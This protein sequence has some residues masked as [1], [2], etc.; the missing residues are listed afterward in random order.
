[1]R[2]PIAALLTD[3]RDID[4]QPSIK[5]KRSLSE[6]AYPT[7]SSFSNEPDLGGG[8]LL[9]GVSRV[10][11]RYE[12]IGVADPDRVSNDVSSACAGDKFNRR[13]RPTVWSEVVE[14]KVV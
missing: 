10:D 5:A 12:V 13:L 11:G 4:E 3:L 2:R 7:I 8:V 1:M 14:G 9:L 6:D